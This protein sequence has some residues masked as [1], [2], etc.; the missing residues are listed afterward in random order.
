MDK[1]YKWGIIGLGRIAEKFATDLKLI[2]DASLHAVA[3]RS[4]NKAKEFAQK[5]NATNY[6]DNYED[7]LDCQDLDIMYIATPHNLHYQNTRMCLEKGIPVLCEK[8]I[9]VNAKQLE[10]L[11]TIARANNTFHM[12]ALWTRFLPSFIKVLDLIK[13][14]VIGDIKSIKADF[15][16]KAPFDP[17]NRIFNPDLAGGSL[18]DIGIYPVFLAYS[19]FG[20][21]ESITA[22]A[23]IGKTG[24]DEDCQVILR[25]KDDKSAVLYSSVTYDTSNQAEIYGDSGFI[26]MHKRWHEADGFTVFRD[27]D[28]PVKKNR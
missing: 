8:P 21:P 9:A 10:E 24:V 13:D 19:L 11:F 27:K 25:F 20:Y 4:I 18:L 6:Y 22:R 26:G 2:Q 3:S 7:I 12:E 28:E 5:F 17:E 1:T 23:T 14:G 15:G 16:F